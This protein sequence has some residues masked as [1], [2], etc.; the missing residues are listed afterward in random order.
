MTM[1]PLLALTVA[2]SASPLVAFIIIA[3][4]IAVALYF[5]PTILPMDAQAWQIIRVV[6]IIAL[7]LW[8]LR[9]FGIV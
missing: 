2:G 1:F 8:A 5:I 9:L 3:V 7:I 4:L 6:V